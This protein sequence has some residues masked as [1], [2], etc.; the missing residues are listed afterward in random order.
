M[1]YEVITRQMIANLLSN[2]IK[3]T[4]TGRIKIHARECH[5]AVDAAELEFSVQDSG[6]GMDADTASKLFMPFTQADSSTTRKYGGTGLGLSII[7]S[8]AKLMGGDVGVDSEPG[9][10]SRFS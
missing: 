3:F 6:I 7:K 2:A 1:L 8:L 5:R 10:G 9:K 4:E